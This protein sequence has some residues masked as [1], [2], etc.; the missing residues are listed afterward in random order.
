MKL[1]WVEFWSWELCDSHP[2]MVDGLNSVVYGVDG[3]RLMNGCCAVQWL[4]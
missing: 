4:F 3:V 2:C 1:R